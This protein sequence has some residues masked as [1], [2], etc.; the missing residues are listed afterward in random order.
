MVTGLVMVDLFH[1]LIVIYDT[2]KNRLRPTSFVFRGATQPWALFLLSFAFVRASPFVLHPSRPLRALLVLCPTA[3]LR[4][5][6]LSCF[7]S[8]PRFAYL[9]S[10]LFNSGV[11]YR[12][13]SPN[14]V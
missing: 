7:S 10:L 3:L 4:R 5:L 13:T 11:I 6:W 1:A 14:K 12:R 9:C 8:L 2:E